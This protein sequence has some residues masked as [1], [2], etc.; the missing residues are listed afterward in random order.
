MKSFVKILSPAAYFIPHDL[1]KGD[2]SGMCQETRC[3]GGICLI[4]PT[5]CPRPSTVFKF[6]LAHFARRYLA[7]QEYLTGP[8][9]DRDLHYS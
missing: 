7:F 4:D 6:P 1:A 5:Q 2:V 8:A 9:Q 3:K